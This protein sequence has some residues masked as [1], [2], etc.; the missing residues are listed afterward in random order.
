MDGIPQMQ[1]KLLST[2]DAFLNFKN[3]GYNT[4]GGIPKI[5][6][7]GLRLT[8]CML[9]FRNTGFSRMRGIQDFLKIGL[10]TVPLFPNVYKLCINS[11]LNK[12]VMS[13]H[14]YTGYL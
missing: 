14:P 6:N 2:L 5:M 12:P 7:S 13:A 10:S 11:N 9:N 3:A 8:G 4:I 1:N